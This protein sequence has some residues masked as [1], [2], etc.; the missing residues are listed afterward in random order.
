MKNSNAIEIMF[1]DNYYGFKIFK[2]IVIITT[3][4]QQLLQVYYI[5]RVS[6]YVYILILK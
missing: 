2:N 6:V 4:V 1:K 3:V 5:I